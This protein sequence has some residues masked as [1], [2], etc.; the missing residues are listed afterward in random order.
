[1]SMTSVFVNFSTVAAC[2]GLP[3]KCCLLFCSLTVTRR[4]FSSDWFSEPRGKVVVM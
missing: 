2:A 1:M 4:S 3:A